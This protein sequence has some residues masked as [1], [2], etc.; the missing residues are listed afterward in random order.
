[1]DVG[2]GR[3]RWNQRQYSGVRLG[4]MCGWYCHLLSQALGDNEPVSPLGWGVVK[5]NN[6]FWLFLSFI[7][8]LNS[9]KYVCMQDFRGR[10][11]L[12]IKRPRG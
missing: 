11:I 1:M 12:S 10:E 2:S 4:H 8:K 3:Q 6:T 9:L 5:L 7:F